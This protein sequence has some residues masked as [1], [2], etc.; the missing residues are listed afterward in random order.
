LFFS[1]HAEKLK[2]YFTKSKRA[3]EEKRE[4]RRHFRQ[5]YQYAYQKLSD[6]KDSW[7]RKLVLHESFLPFKLLVFLK[8]GT[9]EMTP[10]LAF[11]LTFFS[12]FPLL[13]FVKKELRLFSM[14]AQ[15]AHE[16]SAHMKS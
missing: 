12:S 6:E 15:N 11:I 1:L 16:I 13:L 7:L 2:I 3:K 4:G 10:D 5:T 9:A 14:F 8:T